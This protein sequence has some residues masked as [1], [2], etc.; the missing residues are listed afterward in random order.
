MTGGRIYKYAYFVRTWP[1][2]TNNNLSSSG[3]WALQYLK[4]KF[5]AL[6]FTA[7]FFF[8]DNV[9]EQAT[10]TFTASNAQSL[11]TSGIA[12]PVSKYYDQTYR[13]SDGTDTNFMV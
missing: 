5:Y 11:S 6:S 12:D 4:C 8:S 7:Y 9:V 2:T 1:S 3:G 10:N 13:I